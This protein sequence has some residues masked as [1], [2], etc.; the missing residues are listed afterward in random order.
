MRS[1]RFKIAVLFMLTGALMLAIFYSVSSVLT[2]TLFSVIISFLAAILSGTVIIYLSLAP[3]AKHFKTLLDITDKSIAGDLSRQIEDKN[4]GWGE[5]DQ[6]THNIRK[7]L[8]GVHKWFGVIKEHSD[9][10]NLASTRIVAGTEQ[11]SQGSLEQSKQVQQILNS[12]AELAESSNEA[13]CLSQNACRSASIC[14]STAQSGGQSIQKIILLMNEI[15]SKM[16]RLNQQSLQ[17]RNFLTLINDIAKQTNLLALNAAIEAARAGN[18]GHGFSVVADEV[19]RLAESS[20]QA[21]EEIAIIIGEIKDSIDATTADVESGLYT[22]AEIGEA[23]NT[24]V[25]QIRST[26]DIIEKMSDFSSAQASTTAK[27]A[28]NIES[29]STVA[30]ES[31]A[32]SQETAA[33]TLNLAELGQKISR[34]ADIWKFA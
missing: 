19:R 4:Y 24:I 6:L 17:I 29:I 10:L 26:T 27:M 34:V 3:L 14:N 9:S 5:I 16:M 12:I 1:F 7:I 23:I 30:R 2:T 13:A 31:A 33:V 21:T 20:A 18:Q 22:T 11:V 32:T 28:D 15:N 25:A 8:K